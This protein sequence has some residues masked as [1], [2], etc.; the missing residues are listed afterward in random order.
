MNPDC[1]P[2][3]E[4]NNVRRFSMNG[5]YKGGCIRKNKFYHYAMSS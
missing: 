3:V 1:E 2:G 5:V 4:E